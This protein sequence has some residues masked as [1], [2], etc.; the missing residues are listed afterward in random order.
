MTDMTP[1]WIGWVVLV[2]A[3][4]SVSLVVFYWLRLL[5]GF[6]SSFLTSTL[7][8]VL[9][10]FPAPIPNYEGYF[11]PAYVVLIFET[12]FQIKGSSMMSGQVLVLA[13]FSALILIIAGRYFHIK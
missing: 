9:L 13:L 1:Y 6:F 3:S 5:L 2:G 11:A 7:L 12:F 8:F 10:T 4:F